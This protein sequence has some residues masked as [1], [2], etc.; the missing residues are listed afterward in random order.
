MFYVYQLIDPRTSQPFYVGK[1]KNLRAW[2]H[3]KAVKRGKS[4]GNIRKDA[5]IAEI[6]AFGKEPKVAIVANYDDEDMAYDHEIDLIASTTGLLNIRKGGAGFRISPAEYE[7]RSI[8]RD[9]KAR[10]R[11]SIKTRSYLQGWYS[12]VSKWPNGVTFPTLK[13][14]DALA[15]ELLAFVRE[16][17][18]TPEPSLESQLANI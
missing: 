18:S 6:L 1:G 13:N 14:G 7:R 17:L 11:K 9:I 15:D 12:R 2:S 10:H 16:M 8:I 5:F 4:S 3:T